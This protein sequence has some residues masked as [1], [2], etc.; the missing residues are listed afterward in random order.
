MLLDSTYVLVLANRA[1]DSDGVTLG[2]IV[3]VSVVAAVALAV[4]VVDSDILDGESRGVVNADGLDGRVLDVQAL[5]DGVAVEL[6]GVEELG[7]VDT[8][9]GALAVPPPATVTINQVALGTSDRDIG[10]GNPDQRT[11]PLLVAE[12]RGTLEDD[13]FSSH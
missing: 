11:V 5:D 9:V 13:L 12:G 3:A 1:L 2:N 4:S 6:V 7:L 8:A 10:S